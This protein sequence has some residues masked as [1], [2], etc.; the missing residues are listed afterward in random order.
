VRKATTLRVI[1]ASRPKAIDHMAA[2]V[3]KLFTVLC[4]NQQQQQE[5]CS[6]PCQYQSPAKVST[7]IASHLMAMQLR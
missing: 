7:L 6:A 3:W 4:N 2:S 5:T 1:V